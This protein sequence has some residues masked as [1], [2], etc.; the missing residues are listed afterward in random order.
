MLQVSDIAV[1]SQEFVFGFVQFLL[2]FLEDLLEL[3]D[4]ILVSRALS[5]LILELIFQEFNLILSQFHLLGR[6][7]ELVLLFIG[8]CLLLLQ[9]FLKLLDCGLIDHTL[10]AFF[11]NLILQC[12]DLTFEGCV[13][14]FLAIDDFQL[15]GDQVLQLFNCVF[16][17]VTLS[18]L[19]LKFIPQEFDLLVIL[20]A[21]PF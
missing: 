18:S 10:L 6:F 9:L 15:F 16:I 12:S 2:L 14:G 7:V 11:V 13:T 3:S 21:L 20:F 8:L 4:P 5:P 17:C 1:S 19:L